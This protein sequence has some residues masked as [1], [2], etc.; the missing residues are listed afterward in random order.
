MLFAEGEHLAVSD[1][2]VLEKDRLLVCR[3]GVPRLGSECKVNDMR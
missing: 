1:D 2:R 3:H